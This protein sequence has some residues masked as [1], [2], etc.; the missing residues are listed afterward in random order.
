M[1][2]E[3]VKKWHTNSVLKGWEEN[4]ELGIEKVHDL[5]ITKFDEL[6]VSIWKC[7]SFW[8]RINFLINGEIT[9]QCQGNTHPPISILCG[10]QVIKKT[11]RD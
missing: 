3:P 10:D 6:V 9:F 1:S 4:E 8:Q 7:C 5:H 2:F 11:S